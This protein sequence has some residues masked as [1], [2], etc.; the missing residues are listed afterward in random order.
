MP[1]QSFVSSLLDIADKI[2]VDT[3]SE[4]VQLFNMGNK[5]IENDYNNQS[6]LSISH[7]SASKRSTYPTGV[8]VTLVPL[9]NNSG[10]VL[11][12]HKED[13]AGTFNSSSTDFAPVKGVYRRKANTNNI[14]IFAKDLTRINLPHTPL[15]YELTSGYLDDDNDQFEIVNHNDQY[16]L[17]SRY[18]FDYETKNIYYIRVK[19]TDR[20]QDK[21]KEQSFTVTINNTRAPYSLASIPNQTIDISETFSYTIP[22]EVFNEEVGEGSLSYSAIQQNGN[23]LPSWLSFDAGTRTFTGNPGGCN[24]GTYNIRVYAENNYSRIH[25]DFFL[26]VTDEAYQSLESELSNSLDITGL[27][28]SSSSLDE[29]LPSGSRFAQ[30]NFV[31][32]YLPY[33]EFSNS[34]N[35]FTGV[36]V[37]GLDFFEARN[38]SYDF[39]TVSLSGD[40]YL[41]PVSG[42]LQNSSLPDDTR[43]VRA[44]G[45]FSLSGTPGLTDRNI[46]L[47]NGYNDN[48]T[49]FFSGMKVNVPETDRLPPFFTVDS[50]SDYFFRATSGLSDVLMATSPDG[51]NLVIQPTGSD[52][53]YLLMADK[54]DTNITWASGYPNC[55][56]KDLIGNTTVSYTDRTGD[57]TLADVTTNLD[58]FNSPPTGDLK[59]SN[60]KYGSDTFSFRDNIVNP[61]LGLYAIG[62]SDFCTLLSENSDSLVAENSDD[63]ISDTDAHHGTRIGVTNSYELFDAHN[64]VKANGKLML[65]TFD[66]FVAENGDPIVHDYAIAARS[67]DVAL[68]FPGTRQGDIVLTYPD[69]IDLS[70]TIFNYYYNW[71]KLIPFSLTND[72]NFVRINQIYSGIN[73]TTKIRHSQTAPQA[74][75]Y[76]ISGLKQHAYII[77]SGDCPVDTSIS[78]FK[79]FDISEQN[80]TSYSTGL[81]NIY[82]IAGTGDIQLDFNKHINLDS[83]ETNDIN[84]H[85]VASSNESLDLPIISSYNDI[86]ILD[87]DSVKIK[88]YFYMPES[89]ING[90]GTFTAN[91]DKNHGYV[92]ENSNIINRLPIEFKNSITTLSGI[93]SVSGSRPKDYVFDIQ[94]ISGNKITVKDDKNYFLK[95][96]N[97][98]DYFEQAL[99][100]SYLTNGIAFSGSLFYN[101]SNIYDVRYHINNILNKNLV[102]FEYNYANK[103]F[104]F[105][106]PSGFIK[107]FDEISITFPPGFK[108]SSTILNSLITHDNIKSAESLNDLEPNKDS[109]LLE[110]SKSIDPN[111]GLSLIHITGLLVDNTFDINGTCFINNNI[112]NRLDPGFFVNHTGST[113]PGYEINSFISGFSFTGVIPKDHNVL[114]SNLN[115]LLST[116]H[117]SKASVFAT[118]NNLFYSGARLLRQ[119]TV[120]DV[121]F[122]EYYI[123]NKSDNNIVEGLGN[124][125]IAYT[126]FL[127]AQGTDTNNNKSF[128]F[129]YL[130]QNSNS[131]RLSG[132]FSVSGSQNLK[133][134]KTTFGEQINIFRSGLNTV[135]DIPDVLYTTRGDI[136][137]LTTKSLDLSIPVDR[138]DKIKVELDIPDRA[139]RTNYFNLHTYVESD[140]TT[141]PYILESNGVLNTGTDYLP[142]INPE[143]PSLV[144]TP[145][146]TLD[147]NDCVDCTTNLPQYIPSIS[148]NYSILDKHDYHILPVIKTNNKYCGVTYDKNKQVFFNGNIIKINSLDTVKSYLAKDDELEILE[149]NDSA[150]TGN[151][152]TKYIHKYNKT[153]ENNL[154]SG[155]SIQGT[156]TIPPQTNV[157]YGILFQDEHRFNKPFGVSENQLLDKE[158]TVQF[159]KST[160]GNFNLYDYNN[161]HYH[162]YGGTSSNFPLDSNGIY[163]TPPQT[164]TYTVSHNE[165]LCESGTLCV[166]VSGYNISAFTG[167]PDLRDRRTFGE[168]PNNIDINGVKGRIR[169]FGVDK[170]MYFD[171][172][173]GFSAISDDY[174]I[175]DLIAPDVISINIPYNAD[176]VGKSGLVYVIDSDQNIKSHLNPNLDNQLVMSNGVVG[177]LGVANKKIF[178][179]FDHDTKRWKHTVHFKDN[180]M[181]Y[182][183][184]D[185]TLNG[186]STKFLSINPNKIRI[187]GIEYSFDA[188]NTNPTFTGLTNNSLT[189]PSNVGEVKFRIVTLDGDQDLFSTNAKHSTPRVSMSGIASYRV[190][191]D[192]PGNYG[193]HGSGWAIGV[194]WTPPAE[195]FT[196]RE[197]TIKVSDF[198]GFTDQTLSISKFLVPEITSAYT[199]FVA[200]STNWNLTFDVSNIDVDSKLIAN[201]IMFTLS[202]APV[203][204]N[205]GV[206]HTNDNSIVYSGAA[207]TGTGTFNPQLVLTDITTSPF[208]PLATGTGS[209][210]VLD[211][212]SDRPTFDMQTNNREVTY[213]L[214]IEQEER[215][216]FQVPAV[217]GPT[218]SEVLDNFSITLN[219][220]S[221]YELALYSSVYNSNTQRFDIELMPQNTGDSNYYKDSASFANQSASISF[222]QPVYDSFGNYTYQ[223]YSKSFGFNTVFYKPV[224]FEPI[225]TPRT[226]EFGVDSPWTM[227]FYIISGICEHDENQRPNARVYNTPNIGVYEGNP[228]EYTTT[229][230]YDAALKKWKVQI[231]SKQDMFKSYIDNTGLYPISIYVEDDLT[232]HDSND[233]YTIKY[234]GIKELTNVI[235]DVYT[236]PNNHFFSKA[237]SLDLNENNLTNDI[238]FPGSLKE[239]SISFSNST[240]RYDRDLELWQHSYMGDK[241]ED[242]FDVRLNA[243]GSTLALQ[244]KGIGKDKII[245]VAKFDTIEIESNEL[246]GLPLT[247]TGI[248][249]YETPLDSGII[250]DQGNDT[251]EL[252]FK[253]IGGLAHANYPP[254]IRLTDMPTACSGYDPLIDTQMQCVVSEPTW[255]PN[256]R[257]GSWSYH[258]SGVP[259]C[260]LLGTFDI[261][262]LAI[263]TNTGLLPASPY[264]PDT[265]SVDFR[266]TYRAGQFSGQPPQI[267][268]SPLY[269][270]MDVIKPLC[271]PTLY[272]KQLDFGPGTP[273]VCE[274]ATGIKTF[275]VSGSVPPGLSYSTYFPEPGETPVAP[276]SNLGSGYLIVEGYPTT[277]ASG[278]SY[279]EQLT[280]TI[281]D[282]RDLQDTFTLTFTDSSTPNDPDIG[283]AVYFENDK[284][285]LSPKA[286]S[287]FVKGNSTNWRPPPI[288]EAI[289]CNSVL[290]HNKCGVINIQYSGSLT[291]DTKIY[292]LEP[293]DDDSANDLSV[294]DTVYLK[295]DDINNDDLNGI[296]NIQTNETGKYI[297][298]G[299]SPT[300]QATGL[301]RVIVGKRKNINLTSDWND[302]FDGN[303]VNSLSTCLLGGAQVGR[304][305]TTTDAKVGLKGILVPSFTI[306]LSGTS[307]L[308]TDDALFSG[309]KLDRI[310]TET[311]ITS[312][313]S[314]SDCWQ[315]GNVFLSGV[316]V[317]PVHAEIVDPPPA[318]DYFFSFN[319]ARFALATRLALGETE[320]QRLLTDN[321]RNG[322]L[323]YLLEDLV[324]NSGIQS[325]TVGAGNS[326]DTETLT[327]LSGTVYKLTIE[328]EAGD[329]P[330]FNHNE[331]RGD[332]N[333]YIWP[334]KGDILTTIPTQ[335]TFPPIIT[336]G[337]DSIS[338]VNSLTDSDPNGQVMAPV[339][340]IALGG[341]I[342]DDAGIG[343]AVPYN[344]SGTVSNSGAWSTEDFMPKLSGII[345]EALVKPSITG[346]DASYSSVTDVVTIETT[347][348]PEGSVIGITLRASNG[349]LLENKN[350]IVE[351]ANIDGN[352][353]V[354]TNTDLSNSNLSNL[355]ANIQ[356]RNMIERVDTDNNRLVVRHNNLSLQSGD[357]VS[358]D[359][360]SSTSVELN[361]LADSNPG[362]ITVTSGVTDNLAYIVSSNSSTTWRNG[363]ASG[364]FVDIQKNIDDNIKIM[365]YNTT[366]I[367]E[368]KYGFQITG[369]SNVRENEDLIYKVCTIE[370]SG[371]PIFDSSTYPHVGITAKQ[372]FT[373]YTLHV[374]KPIAIATGTVTKAGNTLTFSTI[375]GKRPIANN[376]PDVQIAGG[377]NDLGYCGFLRKTLNPDDIQ[378]EY[379]SANDRLNISLDLDSKYG[380]DWSIYSQIKIKIS[381]ETGTDE[382]TYTY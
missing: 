283:I 152:V 250:V 238:S 322:S 77:Q 319:G 358:L 340:G 272:K 226:G 347:G 233:E 103:L 180:Q 274:T 92:E 71:G 259:S 213:Y 173:D 96:T 295:I 239:N 33:C 338:V 31:G 95:E 169:P 374:N 107:E 64:V 166:I 302:F 346:I 111:A 267:V 106:A 311:N 16:F 324:G 352:N 202:D 63:I 336:A 375:G 271:G 54:I 130:G 244:C 331:L 268:P 381:D 7:M 293:S 254:T 344:Y 368:G 360:N 13:V 337:F 232:S 215:I 262:I 191:F 127:S 217:L 364:D 317:P 60:I 15:D 104:S 121:G 353:L 115:T 234:T 273:G 246:Q 236:T 177:N 256:D 47:T 285:V 183:G 109:I 260:T 123:I 192:E 247:I 67:G 231:I 175:E 118:G 100:G 43:V 186:E 251:W 216:K 181:P 230:D 241:M 50:V 249:G 20:S 369:R 184:Y 23:A 334:H 114:S 278:G 168:S 206:K 321:Q 312:K 188:T 132:T 176:Y 314:W 73:R 264:L 253:T 201:Q 21:F 170:K 220:N 289:A 17:Q 69:P 301:G 225:I 24:I 29:N 9:A 87:R 335:S 68:L 333:E 137:P 263:D 2:Y 89:G 101:D 323:K 348:A 110:T 296:Y 357:S 223:T 210:V 65:N 149:W 269:P 58:N 199:G 190:E 367:T 122:S 307:P 154:I 261:N 279:A 155:I 205:V 224:K 163:V 382:Y 119:A 243:N 133:I 18:P 245:A 329:F 179:Y 25:V 153:E 167:I 332:I 164:G 227:D 129:L 308:P 377:T 117:E 291:A 376:F 158:G 288:E 42:L 339:I 91:I 36:L 182:D 341:Y 171:F 326:F 174:Y 294:N 40:V 359:K 6:S 125:H 140:V 235:P 371:A 38:I 172:I 309:V 138:F 276:Y 116:E 74:A 5:N 287:G 280:L 102:T 22:D 305:E 85:T 145:N 212:I 195:D 48:N 356:F 292:I 98:P 258:F 342:P 208:T 151:H 318:Q 11:S 35:N 141:K 28:I 343:D 222:K 165:K 136:H 37:S 97:R 303:I 265:D 86:S 286:G 270:G 51:D 370:N 12:V 41:L 128:E 310:N 126:G 161:I 363:F 328:H 72:K 84:L 80:S 207:G 255:N 27:S 82:T 81:V 362:V 209:I 142:Y 131:I 112:P 150:V 345:Q 194:K 187:S 55:T 32:S 34:Y 10:S 26:T 45:S 156:K 147:A 14:E 266:Y 39:P 315:T 350:L 162:T 290:P 120:N 252:E 159:I 229:Y 1:D 196:N 372:H 4:G 297:D 61:V 134:Y 53:D 83:R 148:S 351:A 185:I 88:N 90:N 62:S 198:T 197:T 178:N 365:P 52:I 242:K 160:S 306:N 298:A 218:S 193:Y 8:E 211:H 316:V 282:A 99:K 93:N 355:S 57:P 349:N 240:R 66:S 275:S 56:D 124:N 44:Y 3:P 46:Y 219:H 380:I 281:T 105:L 135:Q 214:D 361:L 228:I 373:N 108:Y 379:D 70:D 19:A 313:V 139:G 59:R 299:I 157:K 79:G 189:I 257:G 248:V 378:D 354:Y 144:Y 49:L 143:A 284:A 221:D 277:F 325:G 30:F 204:E 94:S 75:N 237:D 76:N 327:T 78:G 200:K 146:A 366:F 203:P 113:I 320:V 300:I 304:D 330:T